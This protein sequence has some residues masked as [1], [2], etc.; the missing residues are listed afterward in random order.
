ML[1]LHAAVDHN[2]KLKVV[3]SNGGAVVFEDSARLPHNPTAANYA[4]ALRLLA[5]RIQDSDLRKPTKP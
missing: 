5:D 3:L 2:D 4:A 1:M